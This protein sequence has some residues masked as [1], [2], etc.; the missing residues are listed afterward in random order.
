[1]TGMELTSVLVLYLYRMF[2]VSEPQP[3]VLPIEIPLALRLHVLK[4]N[5]DSWFDRESAIALVPA[6]ACIKYCARITLYYRNEWKYGKQSFRS[7]DSRPL[8]SRSQ[9]HFWR[10]GL[11]GLGENTLMAGYNQWGRE[12]VIVVVGSN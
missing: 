4:A 2:S 12:D 5:V 7:D 3:W 1:M 8:F 10:M 9:L 11:Q 6:T